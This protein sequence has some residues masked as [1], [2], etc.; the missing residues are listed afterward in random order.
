MAEK[1]NLAQLN[2]SLGK[3]LEKADTFKVRKDELFA[4]IK[5]IEKAI[6]LFEKLT[7]LYSQ[8]DPES[9]RAKN[10]HALANSI[11]SIPESAYINNSY[12]QREAALAD[13]AGA[14]A[15]H[16]ERLSPQEAK[17][18]KT[19]M[20]SAKLKAFQ[21]FFDPDNMAA[22]ESF[23]QMVA[24]VK[25]EAP[26]GTT[27]PQAMT[28][29]AQHVAAA[30]SNSTPTVDKDTDAPEKKRKRQQASFEVDLV[31]AE[32]QRQERAADKET[33]TA[34]KRTSEKISAE[35]GKKSSTRSK[36]KV[37]F[38]SKVW[39]A[40]KGTWLGDLMQVLKWVG[41]AAATLGGL[42]LASSKLN[43]WFDEARIGQK[44]LLDAWEALSKKLD[45]ERSNDLRFVDRDAAAAYMNSVQEYATLPSIK[46]DDIDL[47]TGLLTR[48]IWEQKLF[49]GMVEKLFPEA[50]KE[51]LSLFRAILQGKNYATLD[52]GKIIPLQQAM[53]MPTKDADK[54]AQALVRTFGA[55]PEMEA[56]VLSRRA[57]WKTNRRGEYFD[58]ALQANM[59]TGVFEHDKLLQGI[60]YTGAAVDYMK[61]A[62]VDLVAWG[63]NLFAAGNELPLKNGMTREKF[64]K[65]SPDAQMRYLLENHMFNL[66]ERLGQGNVQTSGAAVMG[67]APESVPITIVGEILASSS[68]KMRTW[69]SDPNVSDTEVGSQFAKWGYLPQNLPA[70]KLAAYGKIA[71]DLRD[72]ESPEAYNATRE[73]LAELQTGA[74]ISATRDEPVVVNQVTNINNTVVDGS[75]SQ[76]TPADMS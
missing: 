18:L 49:S 7:T 47:L 15:A 3:F 48:P 54:Q 70:D 60:A 45:N 20:G 52:S 25:T 67:I 63:R 24:A 32:A 40:P 64:E 6:P 44:E 59:P 34:V 61:G 41:G 73:R 12:I 4:N 2:E 62:A 69:L 39:K 55:T 5:Q 17:E 43:K 37:S 75:N 13:H 50:S 30:V 57:P 66:R 76:A 53:L 10:Y 26:K 23:R 68:N 36:S 1:V 65:L 72:T 38:V 33:A 9:P 8:L 42:Y 51:Q 74:H 27:A 19:L 16:G 31:T 28:Q 35:L 29:R 11:A 71:R 22:F 46:K 58:E 56:A 21:E 14:D